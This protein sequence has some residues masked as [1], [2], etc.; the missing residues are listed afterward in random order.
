M[1]VGLEHGLGEESAVLW[2]ADAHG[3]DGLGLLA[4]IKA[5]RQGISAVAHEQ[6]EH[7]LC[8]GSLAILGEAGRAQL[9]LPRRLK[10]QCGHIVED[11]A[12]SATRMAN[13]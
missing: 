11:N 10:V 12:Q 6:T 3:D 5:V 13:P 2:H 1:S 4:V 9:I 8:L 7:D